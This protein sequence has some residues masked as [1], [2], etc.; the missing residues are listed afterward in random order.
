MSIPG[1]WF[2][3]L[4]FGS[5][6]QYSFP[7]MPMTKWADANSD[8]DCCMPRSAV[9]FAVIYFK[10]TPEQILKPNSIIYKGRN[11][12]NKKTYFLSSINFAKRNLSKNFKIFW[13]KRKLVTVK[14]SK[15]VVSSYSLSSNWIENWLLS[16]MIKQSIFIIVKAKHP[17]H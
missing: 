3:H 4:F 8:G 1:D 13:F 6:I 12:N 16:I 17:F 15:A 14:R 10:E 5:I 11:E 2:D 9:G 7:R